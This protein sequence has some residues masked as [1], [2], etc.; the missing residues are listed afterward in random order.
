VPNAD[1]H[2]TVDQSYTD[3]TYFVTPASMASVIAGQMSVS[4]KA[5]YK[6]GQLME[7][8]I[9]KLEYTYDGKLIVS[10]S[11]LASTKPIA[12][13]LYVKDNKDGGTDYT[14][15]FTPVDYTK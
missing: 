10:V 12:I 13:A 7:V 1:G 8:R 6:Q 11:G 9:A 3:L 14:T 2:V 15:T 4:L 5:L